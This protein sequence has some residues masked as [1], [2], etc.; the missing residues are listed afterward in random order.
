MPGDPIRLTQVF[1]N[2]LNNAAKYTAEGGEIEFT[3][4]RDGQH[5]V[6]RVRDNGAGI[7]TDVLPRVFD[8]FTQAN[9][10]LARSEGGLGIG[11]TVVR[12]L[13]EK[14]DGTVEA[15][16]DGVGCGSEFIVR[17][18]LM[19]DAPD[20]VDAGAPAAETREP[21]RACRILV[22]D[23]NVDS[24][25]ALELLLR[26]DGHDVRQAA[27]GTTALRIA[28]E[29]QPHLVLCDIGLPGMDGYDVIRALR[30][31]SGDAMPVVAALTG[32]ARSSDRERIKSAGFSY[33]L[34]KPVNVDDLRALVAT[35]QPT[36]GAA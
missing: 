36:D 11:L 12:S 20:T 1:A 3:A 9:R 17:L 33:H 25:E 19:V 24:S 14:H 15:K 35:H 31:Q 16:S 18:P 26:L 22:V 5:A 27:D 29:F 34:V 2:L 7:P 28:Q 8:L 10:S 21:S 6:V 13:V 4:E 23:D 30:D 32:Y